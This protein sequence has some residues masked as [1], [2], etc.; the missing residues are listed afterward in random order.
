MSSS[1][2]TLFAIME[3]TKRGSP[4]ENGSLTTDGSAQPKLPMSYY[5]HRG[6]R[7]GGEVKEV[8]IF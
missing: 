4:R 7:G 3:I 6:D 2:K 5:S 1:G 8:Q